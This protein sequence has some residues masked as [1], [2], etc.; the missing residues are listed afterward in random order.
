MLA[1]TSAVDRQGDSIDQSGWDVANFKNNPVMLWAHDYSALPIAKATSVDVTQQGLTLGYEFAP[2]EGNPMAQ[3]VK[4]LVDEG[5]LNAV[6]VGFMPLERNGNVITK[7]ELFE[8]SF[9]PVPANPQALQLM[10]SKGITRDTVE[11]FFEAKKEEIDE[12]EEK[13]KGAVADQLTAEQIADAKYANICQVYEVVGAFFDVYMDEATDLSAFGSL[14]IETAGLLSS[15]AQANSST[16]EAQT[17][18]LKEKLTKAVGPEAAKNFI[19]KIGAAHSAATKK[20]IGAAIDHNNA[21][22]ALLTG[23]VEASDESG[24]EKQAEVEPVAEKETDVIEGVDQVRA[25]LITRN[26]LRE[27]ETENRGALG[28]VSRLLKTKRETVSA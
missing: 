7:M 12:A 17:A 14:L 6:S 28:A 26:L 8:V 2:A 23:L 18:A 19:A 1:S 25:L 13:A 15:L 21:S 22:T 9:V 10:M 11:K 24:D 5:F 20:A 3:Q 27:D 16:D 4:T